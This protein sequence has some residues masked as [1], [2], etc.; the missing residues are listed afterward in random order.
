MA[1]KIKFALEMADGAKVRGNIDELREHFDIES[2]VRYFLSGKLIEWLDDRYYES[3]AEALEQIDK[4]SPDFHQKLCEA[5]GVEYKTNDDLDVAALE[6][7]NEKKAILCQMT[8]DEEILRNADKTA[9]TQEDLADLLDMGE[10]TI[11]LC[12]EKFTIPVRVKGITYIG[13]LGTPLIDAKLKNIS[14]FKDKGIMFENVVLPGEAKITAEKKISE[15]L[16][17]GTSSYYWKVP[18]E[19]MEQLFYSIFGKEIECEISDYRQDRLILFN[20]ATPHI[21]LNSDNKFTAIGWSVG[22]PESVKNFTTEQKELALSVICGNQYSEDEIIH[23]RTLVDF[24]Y[25]WAFTRDSFCAIQDDE[26]I[27][28]PYD[29]LKF[30]KEKRTNFITDKKGTKWKFSTNQKRYI[31][32]L[33]TYAGPNGFNEE[34]ALCRYLNTISKMF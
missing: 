34:V 14:E 13:V 1:R 6:R 2:V 25:G 26:R 7:L 27:I 21:Y 4:D 20:V 3:E 9:L 18:K 32:P 30:T 24:T 33:R 8:D 10:T 15:P 23:L 11:Y 22:D 29:G 12:G 5:L 16:E 19:K 28:I 17:T 31:G